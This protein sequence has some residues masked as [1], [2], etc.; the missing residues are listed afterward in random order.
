MQT[1]INYFSRSFAYLLFF[2]PPPA[3]IDTRL[4]RRES[5]VRLELMSKVK[6]RNSSKN[7]ERFAVNRV[8]RVDSRVSADLFLVCVT[9]GWLLTQI[10]NACTCCLC[11]CII[12]R[13]LCIQTVAIL[14]AVGHPPFNGEI[15][16]KIHLLTFISSLIF[17]EWN[18]CTARYVDKGCLFMFRQY[19]L[20]Y[21]PFSYMS[22]LNVNK[23]RLVK[24]C[25]FLYQVI[26]L[27]CIGVSI[28]LIE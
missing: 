12:M 17:T 11:T 5:R 19:W 20:F 6:W 2:S 7:S 10:T 3:A 4:T 26:V 13:A 14:V 28:T 1:K 18:Y 24:K 15:I 16:Y 23:P 22:V 21:T 25:A 9:S 27:M 8:H